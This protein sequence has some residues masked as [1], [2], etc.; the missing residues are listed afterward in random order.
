L[1]QY[2]NLLVGSGQREVLVQ[3][4]RG[5]A[6]VEQQENPGERIVSCRSRH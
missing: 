1:R 3:H 5:E 6:A 2:L 4:R